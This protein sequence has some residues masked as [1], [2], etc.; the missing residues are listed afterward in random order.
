MSFK[1]LK[2]FSAT[3]VFVAQF[4][5]VNFHRSRYRDSGS[6]AESSIR[7]IFVSCV[8]ATTKGPIRKGN[9]FI[10]HAVGQEKERER[11]RARG[12]RG[13]NKMNIW[14]KKGFFVVSKPVVVKF[15]TYGFF[16]CLS[17]NNEPRNI[18]LSIFMSFFPP[19]FLLLLLISQ[20]ITSHIFRCLYSSIAGINGR[21]KENKTRER[22]KEEE[23]VA[24]FLYGALNNDT[25]YDG[26]SNMQ[27]DRPDSFHSLPPT[28]SLLLVR[29]Y[30]FSIPK[31]FDHKAA[32]IYI[33]AWDLIRYFR[34][35]NVT[36]H[37]IYYFHLSTN[38]PAFLHLFQLQVPLPRHY[39]RDWK[40]FPI[41]IFYADFFC[42]FDW[43]RK[44][45]IRRTIAF[46]SLL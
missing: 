10:R 28:Y 16:A 24:G 1:K 3:F 39:L 4:R 6:P 36:N 22:E 8:R 11:K 27:W 19:L 5:N 41:S 44:L 26:W 21:V 15:F 20:K 18:L 33:S 37:F 35:S 46:C 7:N 13:G 38:K 31:P 2:G 34:S 30:P 42:W 43:F 14:W 45:I 25:F 17:S 9:P 29:C 12:E 40:F 23:R 32:Y